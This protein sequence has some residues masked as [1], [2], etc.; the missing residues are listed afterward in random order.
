[1]IP[2]L[3]TLTVAVIPPGRQNKWELIENVFTMQFAGRVSRKT[4]PDGEAYGSTRWLPWSIYYLIDCGGLAEYGAPLQHLGQRP[5]EP[6]EQVRFE[7]RALDLPT[8]GR[9]ECKRPTG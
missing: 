6:A 1:M 3:L 4:A 7:N 5:L 8:F 9:S 2:E